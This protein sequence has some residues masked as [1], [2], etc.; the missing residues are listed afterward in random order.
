MLILTR[1]I[2][3]GIRIEL[4]PAIDP[5]T[6]IGEVF[7]RGSIEIVVAYLRGVHVRLGVTAD[8]AFTILRDELAAVRAKG[9]AVPTPVDL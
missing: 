8:P 1:T 6:P 7:G 3:Q 2:G 5:N 9:D 4:S